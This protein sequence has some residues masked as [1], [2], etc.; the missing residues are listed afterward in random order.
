NGT[1][2]ITDG[3]NTWNVTA[4][5]TMQV[6]P[7][8]DA[9]SINLTLEH[10]T[11]ATCD[12]DM[13]TY[14]YTC[15]IPPVNDNICNVIDL[16]VLDASTSG[17]TA[18]D[19]YTTVDATDETNETI[20]SCFNGTIDGSVWFSFT[21][22]TSGEVQVTT[23]IT[24]GTLNDTEIAVYMASAVNCADFSSLPT[25][26]ACAQDG[27]TMVTLNG[28]INF[29]GSTNPLLIAGET[30]Y[31]QVDAGSA[32]QGTFGIEIIDT[33]T[34]RVDKNENINFN[35]FPNP[36]NHNLL[37]LQANKPIYSIEIFN[38]LGQK[39]VYL[40]PE[41]NEYTVKMHELASGNYIVKVMIGETLKVIK[42]VKE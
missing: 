1:P 31:V 11:D 37:N 15:P 19:A 3:T 24:G 29:N 10:G 39:V 5:G 8:A 25:P 35:Y 27:G 40:T 17:T 2:A 22:P 30:Y 41:T 4:T 18:G 42:I 32:T 34:T 16:T 26:V 7:F 38:M 14:T 6:G 20:P 21:A 23:D 36:V 28:V 13:G 12:V 33:Y 9:S